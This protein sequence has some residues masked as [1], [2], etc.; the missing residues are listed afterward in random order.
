[1]TI[2]VTVGVNQ[3]PGRTEGVSFCLTIEGRYAETLGARVALEST[4][5]QGLVMRCHAPVGKNTYVVSKFPSGGNYRIQF[6]M[7]HAGALKIAGPM[8]VVEVDAEIIKTK[9]GTSLLLEA[10][11][12][13]HL[14]PRDVI[15]RKVELPETGAKGRLRRALDVLNTVEDPRFLLAVAAATGAVHELGAELVVRSGKLDAV[16]TKS[17]F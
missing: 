11:D 12:Q 2:S 9:E 13:R 8:K 4:L 16:I 17:L 7:K 15:H 6:G 10:L 3:A 1:M 14:T 5:S